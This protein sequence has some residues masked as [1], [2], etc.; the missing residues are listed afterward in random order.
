M[1]KKRSIVQ[2][3]MEVAPVMP[4]IDAPIDLE[5]KVDLGPKVFRIRD[6]QAYGSVG[7]TARMEELW[8]TF[9]S[10]RTGTDEENSLIY[11]YRAGAKESNAPVVNRYGNMNSIVFSLAVPLQKLGIEVP[12]D[13]QIEVQPYEQP[14]EDGSVAFVLPM[15]KRV[16]HLRGKQ[17]EAE[18]RSAESI[19]A[20]IARLKQRL[21]ADQAAL[22]ALLAKQA[23]AATAPAEG[24]V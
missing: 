8:G 15:A 14:F 7:L 12:K 21:A 4:L 16:T 13:R 1:A 5:A 17:E 18:E 23:A 19:T 24:R 22:E 9:P 3:V 6:A 10:V 11:I 20:E 2:S